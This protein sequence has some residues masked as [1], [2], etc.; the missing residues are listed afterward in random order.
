MS[1]GTRV[2]VLMSI[3]ACST[4]LQGCATREEFRTILYSIAPGTAYHV[5]VTG[6]DGPSRSMLNGAIE[7]PPHTIRRTSLG[8]MEPP[9]RIL[10]EWNYDS[11]PAR[12]AELEVRGRLPPEGLGNGGIVVL[13]EGEEASLAWLYCAPGRSFHPRGK[14][15]CTRGGSLAEPGY[16]DA[17]LDFAPPIVPVEDRAPIPEKVR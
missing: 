5:E 8:K 2:S 15:Y 4:L 11:P 16:E 14:D 7:L 1:L 10:V 9:E 13:I 3:A 17:I 12:S 6:L